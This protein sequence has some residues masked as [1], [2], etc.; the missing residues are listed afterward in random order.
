MTQISLAYTASGQVVQ[1]QWQTMVCQIASSK[2][3]VVGSPILL[4]MAISKTW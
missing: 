1:Q 4:K 3:M 2:G